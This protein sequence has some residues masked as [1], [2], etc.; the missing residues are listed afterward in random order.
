MIS[1]FDTIDIN[2]CLLTGRQDL[3]IHLSAC[4]RLPG[5]L[6][7]FGIPAFPTIISA[8]SVMSVHRIP[9]MWKVYPLPIRRQLTGQPRILPYKPPV[10]IHIDHIPH[11]LSSNLLFIN[12]NKPVS[13]ICKHFLKPDS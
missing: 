4:Q 6:K 5:C 9:G 7:T 1:Y 12:S 13:V 3:Y 11:F 2:G 8:V 10:P